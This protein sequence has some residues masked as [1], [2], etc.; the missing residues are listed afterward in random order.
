MIPLR[1]LI[2]TLDLT[3]RNRAQVRDLALGLTARGHAVWVFAPDMGL[4]GSERPGSDTPGSERSARALSIVSD[5]AELPDAPDIIHGQEHAVTMA[6]LLHFPRTPAVFEVHDPRSPA[7]EPPVFPRVIEHAAVDAAG[8]AMVETWLGI[9]ASVL[10]R[11]VEHDAEAEAR[12]LAAYVHRTAC[13]HQIHQARCDSMWILHAHVT[14]FQQTASYRMLRRLF[15]VLGLER[16]VRALV[17]RT[18]ARRT[19]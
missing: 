18:A 11:P 15:R 16:L 13:A 5:L 6:A 9:Y 7:E 1:V 8:P 4:P 3:A 19:R 10:A 17:S 14:A 2:A 12:A